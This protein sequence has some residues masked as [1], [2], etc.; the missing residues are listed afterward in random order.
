MVQHEAPRQLT[1]R[2]NKYL[3][4]NRSARDII[5]I[6]RNKKALAGKLTAEE[7]RSAKLYIVQ[8]GAV[9]K[10]KAINHDSLAK[11][12]LQ[13]NN[14]TLEKQE[15]SQQDTRLQHAHESLE[16]DRLVD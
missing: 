10:Q 16:I 5:V 6:S 7:Q 1:K 14:N 13:I 4:N 2:E 9:D 11:T 3:F 8:A 15:A 12:R